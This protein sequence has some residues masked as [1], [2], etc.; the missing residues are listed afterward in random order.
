MSLIGGII[1]DSSGQ[2]GE[3]FF[4]ELGGV[5]GNTIDNVHNVNYNLFTNIQSNGYW[6]STEFASNPT[7]AWIFFT[8]GG[9]VSFQGGYENYGKSNHYSAWAVRD[10][11][12]AAVPVPAAFWLF[13]SGLIGLL[14]FKRRKAA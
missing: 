11:D 4:S 8:D 6:S 3:L 1:S 7:S 14:G 2:L 5:V 10:G 13:G 12:V 9:W